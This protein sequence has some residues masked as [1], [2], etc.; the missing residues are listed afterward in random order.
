LLAKSYLPNRPGGAFATYLTNRA[1]R[2]ICQN[3]RICW[4]S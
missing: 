2:R 4:S 1:G 3:R